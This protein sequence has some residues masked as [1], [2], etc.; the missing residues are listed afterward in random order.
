MSLLFGIYSFSDF[1]TVGIRSLLCSSEGMVVNGVCV[2]R[3]LLTLWLERLP[4]HNW[5]E[6][7]IHVLLDPGDTQD[8]G[9]TI[10]LLLCIIALKKL[11]PEDYDPSEAAELEALHLLGETFDA[12][13]QPF[14]NV[15]FSLSQQIESLVTFSHLLCALYLQNGT[16]FMSNQLYGDLQAMVKNA[17]LM[18]P[19]TRLI[20]GQLKVFICLLGDDVLEALFGRCRMIGGHSPNCS[21]CELRDRFGSAMNLDYIYENHPEL[22]RKPRRLKLLRTRDVDHLRPPEWKGELTADSCNLQH[23]WPAG[24]KIAEYILKKYGVKMAMSFSERFK[25]KNTDLMRPF[26]GKYPAIS[27][28]V[29][30]SMAN[31]SAHHDTSGPALTLD[32]NANPTHL[33]R[34]TDFDAMYTEET[35]ERAAAAAAGTHSVFAE[36]DADGHLTHKKAVCR[37]LFDMT[38]DSHASHDRLQRIR[39]FTIGGK[40]WVRE[41]TRTEAM[42]PLTHFQLGNIFS[43]FICHN[44]THLALAL[45]KCTLIKRGPPNSKSPSISAVPLAELSLPS[46]PYTISGQIFSLVPISADASKWAWTGEFVSLSLKKKKAAAPEDISRLRNLQFSV[47]SRLIDPMHENAQE[48]LTSDVDFPAFTCEHEKT[49]VFLN[50]DILNSWNRLWPRLLADSSLH[51]KFPNFTGVSHGVFPYKAES[52]ASIGKAFINCDSSWLT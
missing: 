17:I 30:R 31:L 50:Q 37:T 1:E 48:I 32:P 29:D 52:V 34:D 6:T 27:A 38:H 26:G 15:D 19:K 21:I 44:G 8:V 12:L 22:E 41:E 51:D 33:I 23:C 25:R 46:S 14:I 18:V 45:A 5:A 13:V 28:E 10:K 43:T 47:S 11:D 9:L 36:I 42:S 39:G 49:W 7:S 40:S 35:A 20:N 16:S 4:N 24:V 2:N 3:D